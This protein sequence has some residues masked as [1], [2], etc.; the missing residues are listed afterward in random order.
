LALKS[1]SSFRDTTGRSPII[2]GHRGASG[3]RPEHT[4]AAYELAFS[5]GADAVEPD[6]VATKDG[7]L[8]I[9]HDDEISTTTDIAAHPEFRDRRTTKEIDGVVLT[10]W[11]TEDFTWDE[12]STL[13][14]RE[15]LGSLRPISSCFDGLYPILRF[16]D[17]LRLTDVASESSGRPLG[18][19]AEIKHATYFE[20]IGLP[21]DELFR[22]ETEAAGWGNSSN[23][24]VESF[25]KT[26]LGQLSARGY[27]GD[28]VYLVEVDGAPADRVAADG[29]A[30]APYAT[31]ITPEGLRALS[32]GPVDAR[33]EGISVETR[34]LLNAPEF[35]KEPLG[36][37][38]TAHELGLDVYTWTLRPEN[39]FLAPGNRQEGRDGDFGLWRAEFS[40][41][42]SSGIDGVFADYPD[43]AIAAL[44]QLS[45]PFMS[46]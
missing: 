4:R 19:V 33:V 30:A 10:G 1:R 34:M 44:G 40:A 15:R 25:E 43:L 2:I 42:L 32:T 27:P 46:A 31:D 21:L 39:F 26:V 29:S 6:L 22:T 41:I 45:E 28:R 20:S 24:L 35:G 23:L 17:L 5:L 7:V 9:R 13:R 18:I 8:V 3:Y 14:A 37:I 36:L 12:L 38:E 11:F 16:S